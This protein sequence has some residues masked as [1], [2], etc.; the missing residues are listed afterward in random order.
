MFNF[1]LRLDISRMREVMCDDKGCKLEQIDERTNQIGG[2]SVGMPFLNSGAN[3]LVPEQGSYLLPISKRSSTSSPRKTIKRKRKATQVGGRVRR[4]KQTN[5]KTTKRRPP[6]KYS[7]G[8]KRMGGQLGGKR[9][10]QKRQC[11]RR[12]K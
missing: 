3:G 10:T 7:V 8:I 1:I 2:N 11:V 6:K 9:K 12:R 4:K 5:K